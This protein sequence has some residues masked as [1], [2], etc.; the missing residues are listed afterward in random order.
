MWPP[1]DEDYHMM[2]IH[3]HTNIVLMWSNTW[4]RYDDFAF[5]VLQRLDTPALSSGLAA[6]D[7]ADIFYNI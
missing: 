2:M 3:S 7:L 6:L 5:R 4:S 1:L